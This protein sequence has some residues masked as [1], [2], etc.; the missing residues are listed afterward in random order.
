MNN[1]G[2]RDSGIGGIGGYSDVEQDRGDFETRSSHKYKGG[3]MSIA[4]KPPKDTRERYLPRTKPDSYKLNDARGNSKERKK[5][6]KLYKRSRTSLRHQDSYSSSG[7]SD[8]ESYKT[9]SSKSEFYNKPESSRIAKDREQEKRR[10]WIEERDRVRNLHR[11]Q[12]RRELGDKPRRKSHRD[13]SSHCS[14]VRSTA[15]H[16]PRS[17]SVSRKREK[18]QILA[19]VPKPPSAVP[20]QTERRRETQ[21]NGNYDDY[22]DISDGF[23]ETDSEY[24][25]PPTS[26]KS[27]RQRSYR[28][29]SQSNH[30]NRRRRGGSFNYNSG[31][32]RE[33]MS[34]HHRSKYDY[35]TSVAVSES[36][37]FEKGNNQRDDRLKSRRRKSSARY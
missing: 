28:T 6:K 26:K 31:G 35:A 16:S 13:Y 30:E 37:S 4:S 15:P 22:D 18:R 14:P 34:S 33:V 12:I 27:H 23:E 36:S 5:E 7:E 29:S 19:R 9:R 11:K 20:L 8:T 21:E 24:D 2:R 17:V 3:R 1:G 32:K 25:F 10:K